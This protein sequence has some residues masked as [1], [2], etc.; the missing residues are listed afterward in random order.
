MNDAESKNAGF[1]DRVALSNQII[2]S[3][4]I[5]AAG[6]SA[7][8][9]VR[10][11]IP[12]INNFLTSDEYKSFDQAQRD[13]INAMLR[14]ESG[15]VIADSEFANAQMQYFPQ[16]G[17]TPEILAQKANN[18]KSALE[19]IVRSAGP[20]YRPPK[21]NP[22]EGNKNAVTPRLGKAE[23]SETLFN[24]RKAVK[25]GKNPDAI[26]QRLIEAGIDPAKAG[27]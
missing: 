11:A 1:A 21:I 27:L 26:R 19:G 18:R 5:E 2:S 15:A 16:P 25:A 10:S 22:V 7:S 24:A 20:A 6:L 23:I 12:L 8:Q 4:K 13:I 9:R 14:R 3:P 17:D